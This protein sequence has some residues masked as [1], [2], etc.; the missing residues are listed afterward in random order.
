MSGAATSSNLIWMDLE[1]TGLRPEQDTILEIA[2]VV[3]DDALNIIAEGPDLVIHQPDSVLQA[4]DS[5]CQEHHGRSGL[6]KMVR[7]STISMEQAEQESL[8]FIRSHVQQGAAP[9]CGNSIHQDRRF[10]NRYMPTIDQWLHYRM[11]DVSTL[12]ELISRWYGSDKIMQKS[13][14]HRAMDDIHESIAE[15]KHYR[16]LA[17]I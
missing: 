15:L 7:N 1:M 8:A 11:V 4:M 3:T 9:L 13:D 2:T 5:W 14:G 10:L 17:F 12:K 16:K 6:T